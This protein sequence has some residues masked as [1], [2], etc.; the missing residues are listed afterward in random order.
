MWFLLEKSRVDEIRK[1][2]HLIIYPWFVLPK[3]TGEEVRP[4]GGLRGSV[5][6]PHGEHSD[7]KADPW[8]AAFMCA[9][10]MGICLCVL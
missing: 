5:E 9:G 4:M 2:P 3:Q 10:A 7:L 8:A 1:P 6:I